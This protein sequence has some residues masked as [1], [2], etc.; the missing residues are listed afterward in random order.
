MTTSPKVPFPVP[1]SLAAH[2][3]EGKARLV[4]P[5]CPG[6]AGAGHGTRGQWCHWAGPVVAGA[7]ARGE[8]GASCLVLH[9]QLNW[10]DLNLGMVQPS[11]QPR[12]G[13]NTSRSWG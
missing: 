2:F 3:A 8:T 11:P 13:M 5:A 7:S 12:T 6:K 1:P 4:S 10:W 9:S